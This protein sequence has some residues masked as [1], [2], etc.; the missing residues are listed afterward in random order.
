MDKET[1]MTEMRHFPISD[2]W[3]EKIVEA[4]LALL[5]KE[6]EKCTILTGHK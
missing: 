6:C 4:I 2:Y 1:L 5:K 3:A